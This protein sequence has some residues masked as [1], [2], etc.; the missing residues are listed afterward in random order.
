MIFISYTCNTTWSTKAAEQNKS[1]GYTNHGNLRMNTTN[2]RYGSSSISNTSNHMSTVSSNPTR[3]DTG[4]LQKTPQKRVVHNPYKKKKISNDNLS[5]TDGDN[6]N[7][8]NTGRP[9]TNNS[10]Y[11]YTTTSQLAKQYP[12]RSG[13]IRVDKQ[14]TTALSITAQHDDEDE[15][16]SLDKNNSTKQAHEGKKSNEGLQLN[17]SSSGSSSG[18]SSD[19][20]DDKLLSFIP[21]KK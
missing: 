13:R 5:C 15:Q 21:F 17:I 12:H 20:D 1:S 4:S 9:S 18:S 2:N 7:K 10:P 19:D 16:V 11:E 6:N 3:N 14:F 8:T